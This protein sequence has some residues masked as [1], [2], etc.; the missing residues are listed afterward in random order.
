M[1]TSSSVDPTKTPY[2]PGGTATILTGNTIGRSSST[3]LDKSGMGRWSGFRLKTNINNQHLNI[4][5]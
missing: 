1:T 5:T 3:I 2:Q 4:I